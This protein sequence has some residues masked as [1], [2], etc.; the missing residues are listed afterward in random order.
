MPQPESSPS[1]PPWCAN[2]LFASITD[3]LAEGTA[4]GRRD[5]AMLN[6]WI[7][8]QGDEVRSGSGRPIRFVVPPPG[9]VA[10]EAQVFETGEVP[11]RTDDWHDYFNAL[12]WCV[13]PRAKSACNA[14][15]IQAM[16]EREALGLSGRGACRDALTQF[17]EC[18]VVVA[19]TEAELLQRLADHAWEAAFWDLREA[20][21]KRS[22]FLVFGH[23]TWD[24]LRQ[25]FVGLCAKAV[26]RLVPDAW[27]AMPLAAQQAETDVWLA[28]WLELQGTGLSTAAF[29]PLPVM[30]IPGVTP[31]SECREYY[32]D[33]RQFRPK[34]APRISPSEVAG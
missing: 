19:S 4:S 11:T 1:L 7:E 22:R 10:Y 15:H 18:G 33:T 3:F 25:P 30:G 17:D 21:A 32:R 24:Q 29:A 2:P 8:G 6:R 9:E 13:W 28:Q 23:G 12:A 26:Y 14:L 20:V 5:P 27:M 31:E 34:R 16:R